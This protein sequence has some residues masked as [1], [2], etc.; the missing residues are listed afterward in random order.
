ML[1]LL[2]K[3]TPNYYKLS[4]KP[5]T[6][7]K[8][9]KGRVEIKAKLN[10]KSTTVQLH[11]KDLKITSA[12]LNNQPATIKYL[13]H[14]DILELTAAKP[15]AAD[16]KLDITLEYKGAINKQ[17]HGIY[18]SK[19]ID[20]SGKE[21][22]ILATQFESH[23]AREA[24]PCIDEPA[25][26]SVFQLT[27]EAPSA[28]TVLSNTPINSL[29]NSDEDRKLVEFEPTPI[30]STYLLAFV[31]GDIACLESK[32][33][34][35]VIAK[36]WATP[37][38]VTQTGFALEI[39][40]KCIDLFEEYF[41]IDYPLEKCDFVALPDFVT[42]AMENWGCITFRES[43]MLVDGNSSLRAKQWVAETVA[44]EIAH[45]WFGNLV[46]MEWWS[47]LW[48]NEG[49]ASWVANL[50]IEQLYPEWGIWTDFVTNDIFSSQRLDSLENSHP[51]QTE[52]DNPDEIHGMFDA[53]SYHKGSSLIRML[54]QYMG[55][56]DFK[57][58]L[59][60]YLKKFAYTNATT[61]DLWTSLE[62]ASGKPVRKFMSKWTE[63][64]GFPVL[65]VSS[66]GN[67][68]TISQSKFSLAKHTVAHDQTWPVPIFS[69][70]IDEQ[71][72]DE[73][74][75]IFESTS[76]G[77]T[78]INRGRYGYYMTAYDS[79]TVNVLAKQIRANQIP[80]IERLG[81]LHDAAELN[82]AQMQ[83]IGNLMSLIQCFY[84]ETEHIVWSEIANIISSIEKV[85]GT[86]DAAT[87]KI[88]KLTRDLVRYQPLK[89]DFT[90]NESDDHN[91]KLLKPIL[92][93]LACWADDK[94]LVETALELFKNGNIHPDLRST[95]Y[96]TAARYG[97]EK[98]FQRFLDM[99]RSATSSQEQTKLAS[100]LS[101]FKQP[102]LIDSYLTI[103][104]SD[105]VRLQDV[106]Y[107]VAFIFANSH[108]K[109]FA[110]TWLK[111]NW[112]WLTENFAADISTYSRLPKFAASSFA[113][114]EFIDDYT[115]FFGAEKSRGIELQVA[116]GKETATW[117]A[118]WLS[119]D[120]VA[121]NNW[122]DSNIAP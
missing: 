70:G 78:I 14:E 76:A 63:T 56:E 90:S 71:L 18:P 98:T 1:H 21:T 57:K 54:H 105:N 110:W 89:L 15:M 115:A 88:K 45:Q 60:A 111:E 2:K 108:A 86:D 17:L 8:S 69:K 5:S 39:A 112:G 29:H 26:K 36:T 74:K 34:R 22:T 94:K 41:N 25:A 103:M 84:D 42:G 85:F 28:K 121:L 35:G 58:G 30:M 55:E 66:S 91:L 77:P 53:I 109:E 9:F 79:A 16:S 51:V 104:K 23:H 87:T 33:E 4:I 80:T 38:K 97:D 99:H 113:T 118:A 75:K 72:L 96:N 61:S 65:A 100:A 95:V 27:I 19:H 122:L 102:D 62:D 7:M 47:D 3:L 52:I 93:G 10:Q 81:I 6:D 40:T 117:Q 59:R 114:K 64:T 68:V 83:S 106:F 67:K 82:K 13:Q 32:T 73:P 43:S 119:S 12:S 44:H 116:Q 101:S 31:I 49:F 11:C 48:L 107:W 37:D 20:E 92:L 24:F 120:K 50:A 46:T